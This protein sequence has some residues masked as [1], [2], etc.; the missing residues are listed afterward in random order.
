ML[1]LLLA[2][3]C[4]FLPSPPLGGAVLASPPQRVLHRLRG[5][6]AQVVSVQSEEPRR[7]L[8][9][10]SDAV[11]DDPASSPRRSRLRQLFT[12]REMAFA[13]ESE[14]AGG[15]VVMFG[16]RRCPACRGI[17]PKLGRLA[18]KQRDVKFYFMHHT[19]STEH[20]FATYEI[21]A[22]PTVLIFD[23]EGRQVDKVELNVKTLSTLQDKLLD[24]NRW[25]WR[26]IR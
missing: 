16:S 23:Q 12:D 3:P 13:L 2:A 24:E 7:T 21:V 22:I 18:D 14:M 15:S 5:A 9:A 25:L 17:M 26:R 20:T 6:D 11:W 4:A 19:P 10:D 8:T 1:A